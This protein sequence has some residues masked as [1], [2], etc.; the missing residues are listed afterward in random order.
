M[1]NNQDKEWKT[2]NK[3]WKSRNPEWE[4]RNKEVILNILSEPSFVENTPT[5]LE[6]TKLVVWGTNHTKKPQCQKTNFRPW[7]FFNNRFN[8][9]F[10]PNPS[11]EPHYQIVDNINLL[12]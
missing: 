1:Y 3:D 5:M 4:S 10:H 11:I 6:E 9:V 7:G 12:Y 8:E 2:G